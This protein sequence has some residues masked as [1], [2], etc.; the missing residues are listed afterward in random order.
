ML[1]GCAPKVFLKCVHQPGGPAADNTTSRST[2]TPA[3][4]AFVFCMSSTHCIDFASCTSC[5]FLQVVSN[6]SCTH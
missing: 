3:P 4:I 1:A 6:G 2:F 5:R